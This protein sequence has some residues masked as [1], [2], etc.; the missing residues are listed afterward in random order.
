MAC[1][2]LPDIA[3]LIA[4]I[5][6]LKLGDNEV[7]LGEALDNLAE[8]TEK[9]EEEFS[10]PGSVAYVRSPAPNIEKYL[11]DPRGGLIAVA[12]DI[13]ERVQELLRMHNEDTG[14]RYLSPMHSAGIVVRDLPTLMR[15]FWSVR[16]RAFHSST[17]KLT[18]RD[19][20]RL[21]DLGVRILELLSV[22]K[23]G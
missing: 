8:R 23:E 14:K 2:V 9:A 12:V 6:K 22:T 1:I 21:V 5:R 11:R 19:V 17:V 7:E 15:D 10:E 3:R 16:N 13:E 20:Y 4:R 18:Q